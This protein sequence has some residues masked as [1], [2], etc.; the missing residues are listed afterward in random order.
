[1]TEISSQDLHIS[2]ESLTEF[3]D[4]SVFKLEPLTQ[5]PAEFYDYTVMQV[6]I[7]MNLDL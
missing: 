6:S 5:Q 1:M 3:L 4:N 7:E 2:M